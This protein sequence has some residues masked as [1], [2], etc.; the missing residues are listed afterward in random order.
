MGRRTSRLTLH[1][2]WRE[3]IQASQLLNRLRE[4]AMGN[5]EMT[6]TQIRAA[7]ILLRKCLPDLA[8]VEYSGETE[9]RH[10]FAVPLAA[11]PELD[12]L[13]AEQWLERVK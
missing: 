8:I 13:P 5:I 12:K 3:K 6:P 1:A 11:N 10:V 4:H 2:E 9:I 7:E